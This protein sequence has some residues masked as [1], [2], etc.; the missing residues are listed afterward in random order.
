M[1]VCMY[2]C[3]YICMYVCQDESFAPTDYCAKHGKHDPTKATATHQQARQE[4]EINNHNLRWSKGSDRI[5]SAIKDQ[6][7]LLELLEVVCM[8]VCMYVCC[9]VCMYVCIYMYVYMYV[10]I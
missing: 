4:R 1:Y 9:K 6:E 5:V 8:Y 10:C 3:M 7:A 2:V